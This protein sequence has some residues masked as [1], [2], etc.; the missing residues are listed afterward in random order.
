MLTGLL[1]LLQACAASIQSSTEPPRLA[2]APSELTGACAT[3][4]RLPER[5]LSQAEVEEFW[6][7]DR[8][9]LIDCGLT[10]E[11][12]LAFYQNRDALLRGEAAQ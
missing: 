4:V 8:Q 5:E 2:E 11:A 1:F 6:L 7:R 3:P 9:A 12:L 10:K